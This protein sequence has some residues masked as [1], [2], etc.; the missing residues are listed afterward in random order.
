[1]LWAVWTFALMGFYGVTSWQGVLLVGKGFALS[2]SSFYLSLMWLGTI[3][4][5]L[6]LSKTVEHHG[7]KP[8]AIV[9]F[10]GTA[11]GLAIYANCN[12]LA[13]LLICGFIMHVFIGGLWC[14]LYAYTPELYPTH[15]R[16]TGSGS[17]SACGR[18]GALLGPW[19]VG[20][21]S[22]RY[23]FSGAFCIIAGAFL[24]A[25]LTVAVWG[26]ETK[27]KALEEIA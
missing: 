11:L 19:L 12:G 6:L 17:A 20:L 7:R 23:G 8:S 2:N 4:G 13:Q 25:A 16:A 26:E 1:M 10:L 3:P 24:A 18:L 21:I 9:S 22:T 15:L 5:F 14:S 27:G